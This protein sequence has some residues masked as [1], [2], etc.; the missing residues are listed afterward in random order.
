MFEGVQII[1]FDWRYLY[2]NPAAAVHARRPTNELIGR[3]MADLYPGIDDTEMFGLLRRCMTERTPQQML[4]RFTYPDGHTAWFDLRM[5]AVPMGVMILSVDISLQKAAEEELRRSRQDLAT[6][7]DCMADGVITT[8]VEGRVTRINPAAQELTG[9]SIA[10]AQGKRLDE[11]VHFL[12]HRTQAPVDHP[13][14][15]VLEGGLRIGLANDTVLIARDGAHVPIASSGAPILD[16]DGSIRGVVLVLK[17]MKSEYELTA[18]LNQAQKMEA[19]GQLAGGVAHD[20]NNLLTVIAAYSDIVL[21][22][23]TPE[24]RF[25][26]EIEEIRKAGDRAASLTRQLLAFS[27]KQVLQP[28]VLDLNDVVARMDRMLRRLIGEDIDFATRLE[29]ELVRV[30]VD[31]GQIEQIVMSL[32]VNARDAMPRGGK[33]TIETGNVILDE[34]YARSHPGARTGAHAMIAVSDTGTGMD[35]ETQARIFEPFFTTKELGKGTGLG[36]STVYGIVKQSGGNIWVYSELGV[37][38]TFKVYLPRADADA[39]PTRIEAETGIATGN[40]TILLVEDE[41]AVR[42]AIRTMLRNGGYAVL[43][44]GDADEAVDLCTR[45]QGE[46]HLLLTD[47]V[48][49]G[50]GGRELANRILA[51][52][53]DTK[54]AYMS[55][56]TDDAVVHH[57][58]LDPGTAFIEKPVTSSVLLAKLRGFLS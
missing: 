45:H 8:D 4:N 15:R 5:N 24:D 28:E 33:L 19:I 11:L 30:L 39:G 40:E 52:R 41:P 20:F 10:E 53:P 6:T 26:E 9:W 1:D 23:M 50:V 44:A 21:E 25:R 35:P 29:P 42:A 16:G 27:R 51:L 36:L 17:N 13:V 49:P 18:M 38:T 32:A 7:L 37:G 58:V 54:V 47:V 55:G 2:L 57:G 22:A 56:Y 12:N 31:P 34:E 46:I 3:R 14:E 48:L 43:D